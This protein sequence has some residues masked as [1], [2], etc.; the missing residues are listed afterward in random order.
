MYWKK[1]GKPVLCMLCAF[2]N[3]LPFFLV[4]NSV[5]FKVNLSFRSL[6]VLMIGSILNWNLRSN[7]VKV[8]LRAGHCGFSYVTGTKTIL[9][10]SSIYCLSCTKRWKYSLINMRG[11]YEDMFAFI[12][13]RHFRTHNHYFL[14]N[15]NHA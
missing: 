14:N 13:Q 15:R 6:F 5:N 11:I 8:I 12:T 9:A 7:C 2:F 3:F 10:Q 1:I 4:Y